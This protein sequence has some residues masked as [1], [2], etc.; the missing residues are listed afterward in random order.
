MV[1]HSIGNVSDSLLFVF[2]LCPLFEVL[3]PL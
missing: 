2:A 1:V 3:T